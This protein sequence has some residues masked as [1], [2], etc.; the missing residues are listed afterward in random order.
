MHRKRY[1]ETCHQKSDLIIRSSNRNCLNG[2]CISTI[3]CRLWHIFYVF[4][5]PFH[6]TLWL[7]PW[8]LTKGSTYL[9]YLISNVIW[10]FTG[11]CYE[12]QAML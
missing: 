11:H 10:S 1:F 2:R 3:R 4:V 9:K 6:L 8:H 7:C 12:D 5:P